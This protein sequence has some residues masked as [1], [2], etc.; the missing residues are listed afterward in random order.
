MAT[1]DNLIYIINSDVVIAKEGAQK[2]SIIAKEKGSSYN[3][4][5]NEIT[6]FPISFKDIDSVTNEKAITTGT[7]DET[8]EQLYERYHTR[9]TEP[10]TSGNSNYYKLKALEVDRVGRAIVKECTN[11]NKEHAEGNVLIIISDSNNKKADADL[12]AKVKSHLEDN[13]FI[14]AKVNIISA[15]ELSLIHI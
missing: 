2:V 4:K 8:Y 6:S 14:G 9:M 1:K 7:D 5:A 3:V 13:R 15:N 10:V 11:E 12:I